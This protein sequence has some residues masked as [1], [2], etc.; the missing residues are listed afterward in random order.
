M[1]FVWEEIVFLGFIR[2]LVDFIVFGG[3]GLIV[4]GV[5]VKEGGV[6]VIKFIFKLVVCGVNVGFKCVIGGVEYD[7][8]VEG[9]VGV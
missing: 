7:I 4:L 3:V 8:G 9:G 5:V 2:G 6:C 1:D